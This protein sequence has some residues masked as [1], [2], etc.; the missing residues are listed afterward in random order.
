MTTLG[1]K[2]I[3]FSQ[4]LRVHQWLKNSLLFIPLFAAHQ[5]A[6]PGIWP[7]LIL[8][9]FSFNLCA[10]SAYITNDLHDLDSD[11]QHPRK[12]KRPF[13]A[14]TIPI[15]IGVLLVPLLLLSSF[16]LA[17]LVGSAFFNCLA[18]YFF[19][20]CA[21]SWV[22][23]RIVLVDCLT[24]AMLYT[25]RIIAGAAATH[26]EL[27]FWLLAFSI[28]LFLSLAFVK[29]YTELE[30]QLLQGHQ[31]LIGRGYYTTDAPLIQILGLSAG[32]AATLVMAFYLN[33]N[34]VLKLYHTP[35]LVWGTIPPL[36][37]WISWMWIQAHRGLMHDDPL[38]FAIKDKASLFAG[39]VFVM[40]L[41]LGTVDWLK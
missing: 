31:T 25:I 9:F 40:A 5:W 30:M 12:S 16:S 7:P 4:V 11:R 14:R 24:L 28:F 34:D 35:L 10:S 29:R 36:V 3:L 15:W 22:L 33:S 21:Y 17:Y 26:I 2:L 6:H 19:A 37:F 39:A 38:L 13:A 8:A 32:F 18:L 1:S 20:T 23:K 27:S 41:A